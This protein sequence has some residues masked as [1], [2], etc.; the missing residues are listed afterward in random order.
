MENI[1]NVGQWKMILHSYKKKV[2]PVGKKDES[3]IETIYLILTNDSYCL[4]LDEY[5]RSDGGSLEI[6]GDR[7]SKYGG[8]SKSVNDYPHAIRVYQRDYGVLK[9]N[10][11]ILT[12][13]DVVKLY[14]GLNEQA[15]RLY[16]IK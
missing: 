8:Y 1:E 12:P 9:P 2:T 10:S 4:S 11:D 3:R 6:N 7:Y 15:K 14:E 5:T 16:N 13:M